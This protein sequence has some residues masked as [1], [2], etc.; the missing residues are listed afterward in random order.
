MH[1][2]DIADNHWARPMSQHTA[3]DEISNQ[4]SDVLKNNED[5]ILAAWCAAIAET[6]SDAALA[7]TYR[8][9]IISLLQF[10]RMLLDSD[11]K[12]DGFKLEKVRWA[13]DGAVTRHSRH[14]WRFFQNRCFL[15]SPIPTHILPCY[16]ILQDCG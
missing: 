2:L 6:P 15:G 16:P 13:C 12:S 14:K 8:K 7:T 10:I 3:T 5:E 4:L 1:G 11:N 9:E